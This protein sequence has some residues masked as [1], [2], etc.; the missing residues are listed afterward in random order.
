[1]QTNVWWQKA[2]EW[3]P[4]AKV[5]EAGGKDDKRRKKKLLGWLSWLC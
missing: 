5:R 2:D 1:M 3:L 4:E